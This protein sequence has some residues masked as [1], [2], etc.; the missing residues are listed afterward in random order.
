MHKTL[1]KISVILGLGLL[2]NTAFPIDE[3]FCWGTEERE[4]SNETPPLDFDLYLIGT[5]NNWS[6]VEEFKLDYKGDDIYQLRTTLQGITQF[7]IGDETDMFW[8]P[9]VTGD[10]SEKQGLE[11]SRDYSLR[12]K[13]DQ[14]SVN[15]LYEPGEVLFT[16]QLESQAVRGEL[17]AA[18][19]RV[20]HCG[21][22][23]PRKTY[24]GTT[25]AKVK[26]TTL[27]SSVGA[28][29]AV[30]V[31]PKGNIYITDFGVFG[32]TFG[33][34]TQVIRV[35][36]DGDASVYAD[37]LDGPL[38]S[39]WARDNMLYV[40]DGNEG[41]GGVLTQIDNNG[42]LNPI[43]HIDGFPTNITQDKKGNFYI[44]NFSNPSLSKLTPDGDVL[45][46][47]DHP[48]LAGMVG[49]VYDKKRNVLIGGN[50]LNGK[51]LIIDMNG[52]VTELAQVPAI[53][54]YITKLGNKIY[55][56]GL[57]THR[58]Y[59]ISRNGRVKVLTGTGNA[60]SIDGDQASAEFNF[61]NG[62]AANS[63]TRK[64]YVSEFSPDKNLRE[65]KI[66]KK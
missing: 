18:T 1:K 15:S 28:N 10:V 11:L 9:N 44:A 38:G 34:G 60:A 31:G 17:D 35:T 3:N 50:Y 46:F 8:V 45:P 36:P 16:F 65:I 54:G 19:L 29:D 63:R 59:E 58:I 62:I 51:I 40:I 47:G 64:L 42:S 4:L 48:D 5:P 2:S 61:P 57:N 52:E 33:D 27:V 30:S 26:T 7:R 66:R 32:P 49:I 56:T 21:Y 12:W 20:D 37:G 24:V 43:A 25:R 55:A 39:F 13:E 23:H 6:P 22:V 53:V 41:S 14:S